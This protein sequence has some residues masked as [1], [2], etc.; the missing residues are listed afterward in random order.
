MNRYLI[1]SALC[2]VAIAT[3]RAQ[4]LATAVRGGPLVYGASYIDISGTTT[5][6]SL[7]YLTTYDTGFGV[8]QYSESFALDS[9]WT[10]GPSF[11][12]QNRYDA[13]PDV[14][15]T[16]TSGGPTSWTASAAAGWS[17]LGSSGALV[18]DQIGNVITID[19]GMGQGVNFTYSSLNGT[20][21]TGSGS[22][23]IDGTPWL[24]SGEIHLNG[25]ISGGGY[26]DFNPVV[27][28][29]SAAAGLAGVAGLLTL[30]FRKR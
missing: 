25:I 14:V 19:L 30:R 20:D 3:S 24:V 16:I 15:Y 22:F 5:A 7:H 23:S 29:P 13:Y 6:F 4:Q 28:E 8:A 9:Q 2:C 27:P 10:G 26:L 1:A 18:W 12:V 11:T 17:S 21:W